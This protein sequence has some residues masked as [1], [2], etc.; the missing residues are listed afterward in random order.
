MD[1]AT[2]IITAEQARAIMAQ[3]DA[4]LKKTVEQ[5]CW[6]VKASAEAGNNWCHVNL[7][8]SDDLFNFNNRVKEALTVL[9]YQVPNDGTLS[10][11]IRW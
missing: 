3:T 9:G 8:L 11:T 4:Y 1:D 2:M 5:I 7:P 6:D 10:F